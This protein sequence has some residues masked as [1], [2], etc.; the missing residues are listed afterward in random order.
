MTY[1]LRKSSFLHVPIGSKI[2]HSREIPLWEESEGYL[3]N[4]GWPLSLAEGHCSSL[5]LLCTGPPF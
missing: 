4:M 2:R 1:A 3:P 5:A